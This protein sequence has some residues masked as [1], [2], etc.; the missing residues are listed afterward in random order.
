MSRPLRLYCECG[1]TVTVE[2]KFLKKS[3]YCR[4]ALLL[5][6]ARK[7]GWL[8]RGGQVST[9]RALCVCP[10]C[11]GALRVLRLEGDL[12]LTSTPTGPT[13]VPP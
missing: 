9:H 2:P 5:R 3:H 12:P 8:W 1:A 11:S 6:G 10:R 4:E 13:V 7:M